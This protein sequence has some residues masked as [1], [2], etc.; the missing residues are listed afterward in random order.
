MPLTIDGQANSIASSTGGVNI[1]ATVGTLSVGPSGSYMNV[2]SSGIA[3]TSITATNI[4]TTQ[5]LN[6]SGRPILNQTGSILQVVTNKI[7]TFYDLTSATEVAIYNPLITITPTTTTSLIFFD[8]QFWGYHNGNNDFYTSLWV[9]R[10][11]IGGANAISSSQP[12]TSWGDWTRNF[13]SLVNVGAH[14]D[15]HFTCWDIP[16]T[17]NSTTYIL[18]GLNHTASRLFSLWH[19]PT[20]T[21]Q[22]QITAFEV[23]R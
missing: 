11:A 1:P 13:L 14:A 8:I 10:N 20:S 6:N 9:R 12:A 18:S 23:S 4:T 22:L 2:T 7:N 16:G 15:Y 21:R 19:G 17:T 3:A 5:V